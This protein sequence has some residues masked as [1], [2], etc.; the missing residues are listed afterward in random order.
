MPIYLA[1]GLNRDEE[2]LGFIWA[3]NEGGSILIEKNWHIEVFPIVKEH[4]E[5]F[6]NEIAAALATPKIVAAGNLEKQKN[7]RYEIDFGAPT[8]EAEGLCESGDINAGI[9]IDFGTALVLEKSDRVE[10]II[11]Q[12]LRK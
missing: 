3:I 7:G 10:S 5:I 12:K 9:G 1:K 2:T 4:I 11:N 6:R 8:L